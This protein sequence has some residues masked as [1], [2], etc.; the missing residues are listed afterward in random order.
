MA[1][2]TRTKRFWTSPDLATIQAMGSNH[3]LKLGQHAWLQSTESFYKV[4][5]VNATTSVWELVTGGAGDVSGTASSIDN[6]LVRYDSTTGK[7]IQDGG[8]VILSDAG[9]MRAVSDGTMD[10]GTT[11]DDTVAAV[12]LSTDGANGATPQIFTGTRD[13]NGNVTGS[14]G[15]FYYRANGTSS[16]MYQHRGASPSDSDWTSAISSGTARAQMIIYIGGNKTVGTDR[17]P[18]VRP[19]APGIWDEVF[20][21]LNFADAGTAEFDVKKNGTTIFT[22]GN[23]QIVGPATTVTKVL[24]PTVAYAKDDAITVDVVSGTTWTGATIHLRGTI[25][26]L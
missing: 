26:L 12:Q 24:S 21:D 2:A 15:D 23:P 20:I 18:H 25:N 22:G 10:I 1:V 3:G 14:P 19:G 17:A 9:E 7:V 8:K 6:E 16:Q 4:T 13:P 5:T 11:G